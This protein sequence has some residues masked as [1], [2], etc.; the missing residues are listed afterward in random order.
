[1][2]LS[3]I[4]ARRSADTVGAVRVEPIS[5]AELPV[6]RSEV[7]GGVT[8]ADVLAGTMRLAGLVAGLLALLSAPVM[9]H[10]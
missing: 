9:Q 4:R 7:S 2:L 10:S 1:M 5:K 8:R 6:R 3:V